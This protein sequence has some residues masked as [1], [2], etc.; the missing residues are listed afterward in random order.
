MPSPPPPRTAR[1]HARTAGEI[2][3]GADRNRTHRARQFYRRASHRLAATP[4]IHAR[5]LINHLRLSA[6]DCLPRVRAMECFPLTW[7]QLQ[8]FPFIA[9]ARRRHPCKPSLAVER[10][11]NTDRESVGTRAADHV[12]ARLPTL[13]ILS[14]PPHLPY[15][16]PFASL[17]P[18]P[19]D[20]AAD[21]HV[22]AAL[23][24]ELQPWGTPLPVEP[25]GIAML[26]LLDRSM[27]A[28]ESFTDANIPHVLE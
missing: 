9:R 23:V 20:A 4:R 25:S 16:P 26:M 7:E 1:S 19:K 22:A 6:T 17:L 21:S 10:S 5:W 13:H 12:R 15:R 28:P 24:H 2:E 14:R 18:A 11:S 3:R 27:P 8:V